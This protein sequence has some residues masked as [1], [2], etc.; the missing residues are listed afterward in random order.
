MNNLFLPRLGRAAKA[1]TLIELLVVIVIIGILAGIL[2]PALSRE[3]G[4]PRRTVRLNHARQFGIAFKL[5]A[6]DFRRRRFFALFLGARGRD[7]R[8]GYGRG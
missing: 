1:F 2:L 8:C 7:F 6:G 3:K 4:K 5:Y